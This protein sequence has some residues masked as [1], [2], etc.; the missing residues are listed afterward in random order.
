MAARV[1][2]FREYEPFA[3]L[4]TRYWGG[5]FHRAA[6]PMLDQTVLG[7]LKPHAAVLDLCCGDGR[8][9]TEL[10]RRGFRVVGLDSSEQ[11]LA[12]ARQRCPRIKFLLAD[13][14]EFVLPRRFDAAISTFDSLNHILTT[15][16]LRRVMA[17]VW[18]CL[19]PNGAFVFDLNGETAYREL[20]A[21]T[22][23]TVEEEVVSIARGS[24]DPRKHLARCDVTV[25]RLNG[26][27]WTRS[28]FRL[29]QRHHSRE[30]VLREL[31]ATGFEASVYDASHVGMQ[32]HYAIGRD[33]YVAQKRDA[34]RSRL[35]L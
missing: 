14:R 31:S 24:Y 29:R 26:G 30:R 2:R 28:D 13:A 21:R 11:M 4:Y 15:P 35:G 9:S 19:K 7:G 25:L 18:K 5:L 34:K 23:T 6:L 12:Y 32:G 3:W 17:N 33:V 20:W 1:R 10:D 8:L 22:S 16:G 27:G